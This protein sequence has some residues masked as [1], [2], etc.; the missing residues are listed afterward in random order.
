MLF[1]PAGVDEGKSYQRNRKSLSSLQA[2]VQELNEELHAAK[3]SAKAAR[4]RETALKEELEGLN[5]DLQR[6]Q[7]AQ[8]RTQG[9][10]EEREKEIQELKQRIKRLSGGL[11]IRV[12]HTH[13]HKLDNLPLDSKT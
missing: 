12:T 4:G 3:D 5:Q 8:S 13:T 9:E 2:R 10:K 1:C 7:K 11:Q 6:S